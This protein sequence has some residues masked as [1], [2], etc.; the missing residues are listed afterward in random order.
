MN[1]K[2]FWCA[3]AY[4][5][6]DFEMLHM[7]FYLEI[8]KMMGTWILIFTNFIPISLM[9]TLEMVKLGQSFF[10]TND[11]NMFDEETGEKMRP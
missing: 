1:F 5:I 7:H 6:L 10:M 9:T 11:A 8:V 4:Y 2:D 3:R